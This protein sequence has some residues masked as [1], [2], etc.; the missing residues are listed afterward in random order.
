MDKYDEQLT[1]LDSS[2]NRY[3]IVELTDKRSQEVV[4]NREEREKKER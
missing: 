3:I 2:N 1:R 4:I